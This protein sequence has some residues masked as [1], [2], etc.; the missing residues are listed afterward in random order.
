MSVFYVSV[1]T[2]IYSKQGCLNALR[3]ANEKCDGFLSKNKYRNIDISPSVYYI[4]KEL[5]SWNNAKKEA[6][7]P[8]KPGRDSYTRQDC[9]NAIQK[10]YDI[11]GEKPSIRQYDNLGISPSR[12]V[13]KEYFDRWNIAIREAG[14][15]PRRSG[16]STSETEYTKQDCLT[17][18]QKASRLIGR[19]PTVTEYKSLDISPSYTV[20]VEKFGDFNSA[21]EKAGLSCYTTT[22][23]PP[24]NPSEKL[25]YG[26]NWDS[27]R[28]EV[29]DKNDH[30]CKLC[31]KSEQEHIHN[32]DSSLHVHHIIK[33]K[34]FNSVII[35]NHES[36]L[37]PL[38]LQCHNYIE[39]KTV[40]E[41]CEK[42]NMNIPAVAEY[43]DLCETDDIKQALSEIQTETQ[44]C[45]LQ[46]EIDTQAIV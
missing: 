1:S 18:L 39:P 13:I 14:F 40:E 29:I 7:L 6:G 11:L 4:Q 26:H 20:I 38:C 23:N 35:A 9:I 44:E 12:K 30:E 34:Q 25:Y 42:L 31:G 43:T 28:K 16:P 33:F 24:R 15:K 32:Y 45:K 36:N 10:A 41:Q 2:S 19:S 3:K 21:K 37:V 5:G 46:A 17:A 22:T 27:I 8:T